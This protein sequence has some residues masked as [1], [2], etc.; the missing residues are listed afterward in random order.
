MNF[1]LANPK[2]IILAAH[3]NICMPANLSVMAGLITKRPQ[4]INYINSKAIFIIIFS[5]LRILLNN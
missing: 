4:H 2:I 1:C 3:R 5:E